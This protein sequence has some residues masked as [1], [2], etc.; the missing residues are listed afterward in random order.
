ME[1]VRQ[2]KESQ[3]RSIFVFSMFCEIVAIVFSQK[4]KFFFAGL[5]CGGSENVGAIRCGGKAQAGGGNDESISQN[6]D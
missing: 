3:V 5:H 4:K 2:R 6:G 1:A